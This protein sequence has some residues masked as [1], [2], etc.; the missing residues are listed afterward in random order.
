LQ[1][2]V[3]TPPAV[4]GESGL[5]IKQGRVGPTTPGVMV[6]QHLRV[7]PEGRWSTL[8]AEVELRLAAG[9]A[10]LRLAAPLAALA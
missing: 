1:P 10:V 5:A 7:G 3:G 9:R 8:Q 6:P 4:M 2:V